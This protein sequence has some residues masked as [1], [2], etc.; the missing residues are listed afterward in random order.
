V[1]PKSET[2][3]EAELDAIV[4]EAVCYNRYRGITRKDMKSYVGVR[5]KGQTSDEL[6]DAS[7]SRLCF[8][9][10]IVRIGER[11]L[12]HCGIFQTAKGHARKPEFHFE[13]TWIL[14]CILL[15]NENGPCE[16]KD[17]IPLADGINKAIPT[18]DELHGALNRL[19]SARLISTRKGAYTPTPKAQELHKKVK[20]TCRSGLWDQ[21]DGLTNI[22]KCP[23]CGVQLKRVMW[24][25]NV[26]DQDVDAAY[27]Q[28]SSACSF[29]GKKKKRQ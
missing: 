7:L 29:R 22:L 19:L 8:A 9:D 2:R 16:I 14:M 25:I 23:C 18:V 15:L 27:K 17:I 12:L 4:L 24:R 13:D 20:E 6:L 3:S 10:Q 21:M 26:T 28:Y 5:H 1:P 11:W